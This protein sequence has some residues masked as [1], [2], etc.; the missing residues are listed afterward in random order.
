MTGIYHGGGF[1]ASDSQADDVFRL[2]KAIGKLPGGN[3]FVTW[4]GIFGR[5]MNGY[6]YPLRNTKR[7]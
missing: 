5:I 7:I 2:D 3:K 1:K 4:W 6:A